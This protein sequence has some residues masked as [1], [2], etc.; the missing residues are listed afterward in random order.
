[1]YQ[2]VL[3]CTGSMYTSTGSIYSSICKHVCLYLQVCLVQSASWPTFKLPTVS[4]Y[5][6]LIYA[7]KFDRYV[8]LVKDTS[9]YSIQLSPPPLR[10]GTFHP[11][12]P[13]FYPREMAPVVLLLPAR[14]TSQWWAPMVTSGSWSSARRGACSGTLECQMRRYVAPNCW[15][16]LLLSPQISKLGSSCS[17]LRSASWGGGRWST[18]SEPCPLKQPNREKEVWHC[19]VA[20]WRRECGL[21]NL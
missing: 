13:L 20:T 17:P 9:T 7:V 12:P 2:S 19:I 8:C 15:M 1:M 5:H 3:Q 11:R 21:L 10:L 14:G 16:F 6:W 18:W 4:V